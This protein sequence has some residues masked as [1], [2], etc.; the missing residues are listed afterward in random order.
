MLRC[1]KRPLY[2]LLDTCPVT[3]RLDISFDNIPL[4]TLCED[5]KVANANYKPV[6]AA[7]LH[8]RLADLAAAATV[9]DLP[10]VGNPRSLL[11]DEQ[12]RYVLDLIPPY[13]LHFCSAHV[14][15]PCLATGEVEWSK[16]SRIK[17][18]AITKGHV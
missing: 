14:K 2:G 3:K 18:L 6:V 11:V 15:T 5:P 9:S 10:P 8:G 13:A 1:G 4:R 7:A 16:V 17:L 12:A